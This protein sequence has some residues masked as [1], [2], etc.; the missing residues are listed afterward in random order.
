MS[1]RNLFICLTLLAVTAALTPAPA[2]AVCGPVVIDAGHGGADSGAVGPN[3]LT[4]KEVNLDIAL[5]TRDLLRAG[6][7]PVVMTRETD[8]SPNL[9]PRDLTGDGSIGIGD[10]LQARVDI[11]NRVG[12]SIFVAI[13]NNASLSSGAGGTETYHWSGVDSE[14]DSARL[15]KVIQEE[16]VSEIGLASRGVYGANFYVLRRTDMPAALV[17]G[18]FLSNPV[19][20][21]LLGTP[22]FR[23]KIAQGVFDGIKRYSGPPPKHEPTIL[24][25]N[26]EPGTRVEIDLNDYLCE[27]STGARVTADVPITAERSIYLDKPGHSGGSVSRGAPKPSKTWYLAE[28]TTQNGFDSWLLLANPTQ[29]GTTAKIKYMTETGSRNPVKVFIPA[30]SRRSVHVNATLINKSFGTK[31]TAGRPIVVERSVYF[32]YGE[33]NGMHTSI[34]AMAPAKQWY[35][36]EGRTSGRNDT[37]IGLLNPGPTAATVHMRYVTPLGEVDGGTVVIPAYRRRSVSVD[38]HVPD[39][40]VSIIVEADRGVVAERAVYFDEGGIRGGSVTLGTRRPSYR[41]YFAEGNTRG[42]RVERLVLFNPGNVSSVV[43]VE[44]MLANGSVIKRE[45]EVAAGSRLVLSVD[46]AAEAGTRKRPS[47]RLVASAPIVA[48]RVMFFDWQ[49]YSGGHASI[50]SLWM[51]KRWYFAAGFTGSG[52]SSRLIIANPTKFKAKVK[53]RLLK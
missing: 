6:G 1:L 8:I 14:S 39:S 2:M 5:R 25:R 32:K 21:A 31:V 3:G 23:Q 45:R 18:G 52:H 24:T 34:G 47:I 37:W 11:A 26:L 35:F 20:E 22:S 42:G 51:S 48:E 29:Y 36:A 17:E 41:W 7:Y 16:I 28:G 13:H 12:A 27:R 30:F 9:P 33:M 50:G 53:V 19:E 40:E 49:G 44:Y 38:S 43:A 10:D 46:D 4:E 15:A